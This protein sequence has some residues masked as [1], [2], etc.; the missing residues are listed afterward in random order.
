MSGG[1][2]SLR[3][4]GPDVDDNALFFGQKVRIDFHRFGRD[5]RISRKCIA[6]SERWQDIR[7][8]TI[9]VKLKS[10]RVRDRSRV[11]TSLLARLLKL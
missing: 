5:K 7:T 6:Y 4:L 8:R 11:F 9:R 1:E 3:V 2:H 10:M